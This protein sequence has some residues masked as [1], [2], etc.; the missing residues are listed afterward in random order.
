L[1]TPVTADAHTVIVPPTSVPCPGC[2]CESLAGHGYACL[3]LDWSATRFHR[4]VFGDGRGD[5]FVDVTAMGTWHE[6]SDE[7]EAP[8]IGGWIDGNPAVV[9]DL[10]SERAAEL[11][12]L[13]AKAAR[14]LKER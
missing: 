7:V 4:K 3:D 9:D 12:E 14:W 8:L 6:G 13:L 2:W 1:S 5:V 10:T 11:S